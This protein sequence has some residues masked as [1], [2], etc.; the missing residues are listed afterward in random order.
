MLTFFKV[1]FMAP[2]TPLLQCEPKPMAVIRQTATNFMVHGTSEVKLLSTSWPSWVGA[3]S[4]WASLV[5]T[6]APWGGLVSSSIL[7]A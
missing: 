6:T 5:V 3:S 7:A 1:L 2:V 4:L